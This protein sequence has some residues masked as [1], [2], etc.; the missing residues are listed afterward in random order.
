MHR[1]H[2]GDDAKLLETGD[3][4]QGD[5]CISVGGTPT[6]TLTAFVDEIK[7]SSAVSGGLAKVRLRQRSL[8]PCGRAGGDPTLLRTMAVPGQS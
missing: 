8:L 5:I 3:I 2:G 7:A 6:P 4:F 1:L